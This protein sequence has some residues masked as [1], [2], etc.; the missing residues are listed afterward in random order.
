M[1]H[2]EIAAAQPEEGVLLSD[3]IHKS[4]QTVADRFGLTKVNCPRHPSNCTP[5]WIVSDVAR[6][7]IFYLLKEKGRAIGCVGIEQKDDRICYMERLAI[8]P[9]KRN[10]GLGKMLADHIFEKAGQLACQRVRIAIIA[11]QSELKEWYM[12]M[13]FKEG[14]TKTF[15]HLPFDVMFMEKEL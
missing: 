14:I 11:R 10:Q 1:A 5:E 12:A 6:G 13:G 3:I 8:L 15:D 4:F 9:E 2:L 7:V